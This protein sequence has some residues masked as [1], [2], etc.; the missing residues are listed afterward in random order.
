MNAIS[1]NVYIDKEH[2]MVNKNNDI[3]HR[4]IKIKPNDVKSSTYTGF[5]VENNDTDIKFKVVNPL[6]ISKYKNSFAKGYTPYWSV[7][8]KF[9]KKFENTVPWTNVIEEC[10]SE[11]TA[12]MIFEKELQKTNQTEFR[13]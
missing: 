6:R 2:N 10:N 3:Y 4:I 5:D 7:K 13:I 1:K 9:I 11:E 8:K 12:G